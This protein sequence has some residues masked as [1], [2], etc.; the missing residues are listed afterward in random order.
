VL[1]LSLIPGSILAA[2]SAVPFALSDVGWILAVA[3]LTLAL[4]LVLHAVTRRRAPS[5]RAK[6]LTR[7]STD[8]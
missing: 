4:A 6:P 2:A 3:A 7:R 5:R 1:Q 8:P